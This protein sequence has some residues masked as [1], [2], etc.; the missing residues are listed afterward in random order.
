[1]SGAQSSPLGVELQLAMS[2][3]AHQLLNPKH[4]LALLH[5]S[6]SFIPRM[7]LERS[8]GP[9]LTCLL[10]FDQGSNEPLGAQVKHLLGNC[11]RKGESSKSSGCIGNLP[12][13]SEAVGNPAGNGSSIHYLWASVSIIS[14]L[15]EETIAREFKQI[16]PTNVA[17]KLL[18]AYFPRLRYQG[19]KRF[20]YNFHETYK[21]NTFFPHRPNIL[22]RVGQNLGEHYEIKNRLEEL[23]RS[24]WTV[25]LQILGTIGPCGSGFPYL[26]EQIALLDWFKR[27]MT[28]CRH[29]VN[30][31]PDGCDSYH[32][33]MEIAEGQMFGKIRESVDATINMNSY[34]VYKEGLTKKSIY[35]SNPQSLINQAAVKIVGYYYKMIGKNGSDAIFVSN[36]KPHLQQVDVAKSTRVKTVPELV[37]EDSVNRCGFPVLWRAFFPSRI[38]DLIP[39][40]FNQELMHIQEKMINP[41]FAEVKIH[42]QAKPLTRASVTKPSTEAKATAATTPADG[43]S[44]IGL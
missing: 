39:T 31:N 9:Q 35:V 19:T 40:Q 20:K 33:W 25:N 13:S 21:E 42:E 12:S 28:S 4:G 8:N 2:C 24:M 30:S 10:W 11:I 17:E 1:M 36:A 43:P 37:H 15:G 26:K 23:A 27:F 7:H 6:K 44:R 3:N 18:T 5:P 32:Q 22:K 38:L 41:V 34:Q 16:A 29:F 14:S